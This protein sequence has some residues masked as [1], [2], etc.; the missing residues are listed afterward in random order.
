MREY[1]RWEY[2]K[3][4]IPKGPFSRVIAVAG[5]PTTLAAL[6]LQ[7]HFDANRIHGFEMSVEIVETWGERLSKMSV[8]EREV[9]PGME[10]KRADVLVAGCFILSEGIR[11]V[12]ARKIIVSTRGVRFGLAAQLKWP[13]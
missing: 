9:L 13:I 6:E 11:S 8:A 3:A 1:L 10:P 4:P 5:T 2:A 12:G 7:S